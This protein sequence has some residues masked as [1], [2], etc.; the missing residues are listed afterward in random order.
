VLHDLLRGYAE[1][2]GNHR[3]IRSSEVSQ[4]AKLSEVEPK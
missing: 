2:L 4:N 3:F 1:G